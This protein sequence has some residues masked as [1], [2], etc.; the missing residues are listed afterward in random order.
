MKRK[1]MHAFCR[2]LS[3]ALLLTLISTSISAQDINVNGRVIDENGDPIIGANVLIK[4]T[5]IGTITN[6]DGDFTIEAPNKDAIIRIGYIGYEEIEIK[7]GQNLTIVMKEN[8]EMLDDVVVIGYGTVKKSDATGS[9]TA[10]KP[11]D[12]NKGLQ[13]TAQDALV[14]KMSGVN[15]VSG[16]GAPVQAQPSVSVAEPPCPLPTIR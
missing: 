13:T 6:I 11:D 10:I 16:S 1:N 4:G 15:V 14:G 3:S 7:A 8:S 5:S 12:F 2:R 9:V